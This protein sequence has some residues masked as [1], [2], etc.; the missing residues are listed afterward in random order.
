M[1]TPLVREVAT[2]MI[3]IELKYTWMVHPPSRE[4]SSPLLARV[5][6]EGI[7]VEID[8]TILLERLFL[9]R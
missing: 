5:V 9:K 7:L 1:H 3:R 8:D 2:E 6:K 4:L